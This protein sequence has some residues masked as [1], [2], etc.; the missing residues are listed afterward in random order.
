MS[1]DMTLIERNNIRRCGS[2]EK[3]LLLAHGFGCDQNM[4]RFL[5]PLLEPDF[6]LVLFDYV[7]WGGSSLEAYDDQRYSTLVGYAED[8][9]QI[10]AGLNLND[11]TIVGHSVSA[12]IGLLASIE[13]PERFRSHVMVCPSPCFLNH[14]PEYHGGFEYQDIEELF[15]LLDKN[16]IGWAE[17]LAPLVIG[18]SGN[19]D[20]VRELTESFCSTD[21]VI[22]RNFAQATFYSDL[23]AE[24]A[25]IRHPSLLLQSQSDTLASIEVGEYMHQ[26]MPA[27]VL[28][29]LAGAGHCLHMTDPETV[30]TEIREFMSLV[31]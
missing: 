5:V 10:C 7:G 2:G 23:R 30:A 31:R 27:S 15:D 11:V 22:A 21:P 20:F 1:A 19:E 13:R 18:Q 6:Q 9:N 29:I 4:W 12:M 25:Q 28:R 3:T 8:I 16:F 24:L 14:P 17:Y 26:R